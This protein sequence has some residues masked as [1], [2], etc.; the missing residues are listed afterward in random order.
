MRAAERRGQRGRVERSAGDDPAARLG[1]RSPRDDREA[2]DAGRRGEERRA[3]V[4]FLR[5]HDAESSRGAQH[6]GRR[7]AAPP[8]PLHHCLGLRAQRAR[9]L[10]R[11]AQGEVHPALREAGDWLDPGHVTLV[12]VPDLRQRNAVD[13]L[14]PKVD[15]DTLCASA[16]ISCS[17]RRWGSPS[18]CATRATSGSAWTSR[19]ASAPA[20]SSTS[21]R[22]AAEALVDHLSPWARPRRRHR[23]RRRVY[24]S[25]LLDF[26]EDPPSTSTTS[27]TSA[28]TTCAR[29]RR[30]RRRERGERRDARRDPGLRRDP[31]HRARA[32]PGAPM[33]LP[34]S[35]TVRKPQDA[36]PRP[37][38]AAAVRARACARCA[39]T[40]ASCG[41]TTTSTTRASRRSSCSATRSPTCATAPAI[42]S[43]TCSPSAADDSRKWR[44]SSSG[45]AERFPMPRSRT[46]LSQAA[47]RRRRRA[48]RLDPCRPSLAAATPT[49]SRASS[50]R[51]PGRSRASAK[52]AC[53]G[54][55]ARSSNTRGEDP[56]PAD[57][58]RILASRA[59]R[60][61]PSQPVRGLHRR[62]TRS[63]RSASCCAPRS[64]SSRRRIRPRPTRHPARGAAAPRAR[65]AAPHARRDASAHR[66]PTAA[67]GPTPNSSKGRRSST[68]SS[69]MPSSP[70]PSCARVSGSRTSSPCIMDIGGVR[71]VRDIVIRPADRPRPK[72]RRARASGK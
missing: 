21:T 11:G 29:R 25:V 49:R 16:S 69:T 47:D 32:A 28:C 38:P 2:Q 65:R 36:P 59:P 56:A 31:R 33:S 62:S 13:P 39:A 42:R 54:S 70:R 40:R 41:P 15:A 34:P 55:T 19:C 46:R 57:K 44:A 18:T 52:C 27:P 7:A 67:A 24:K 22:A 4:R 60:C 53:A 26:V 61:R 8:Q 6:A 63:S 51:G 9:R 30:R 3:A 58:A 35:P 68:A 66:S 20:S 23:L 37:R 71:A 64:R 1:R 72:P 12:V 48:Q 50:C 10:S 17:A 45:R 14:Q 43:R 5:R